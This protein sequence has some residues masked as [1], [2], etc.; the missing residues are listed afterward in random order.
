MLRGTFVPPLVEG[1]T[2]GFAAACVEAAAEAFPP[3]VEEFEGMLRGG[4][5]DRERLL[6]YYFARLESG[7]GGCTM[8][9]V[10]PAL[11]DEGAGP[12]VGRNYD[13]AVADL[14][15]CE[16]RRFE[17]T[18]GQRRIGYT[19]HWAGCADILS[20]AGLYVAIASLPPVDVR[21]PGVQWN[22]VVDMVSECCATVDEAARRC[23]GVRHLRSMSYLLADA[24]GGVGIVEATPETVRFRGPKRDAPDDDSPAGQ[25]GIVLAANVALGGC[26]MKDWTAT[27]PACV[28]PV[29]IRL[30]SPEYRRSP[31][32]RAVRRVERARELLE[33]AAP[34]ISLRDVERVLRDHRAPICTGDH[35][36]PDGGRAGTIWS[37]VS[38]PA[39][40]EFMIA[41]G[42]P[43]R[44][45]YQRFRLSREI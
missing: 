25:D 4:G 44:H 26:L 32:T 11:R 27:E 28:L 21:A 2:A 5:F 35:S 30:A 33:A 19:H 12:V 15:W 3:A 39:R 17:Q 40:G 43:C 22:I 6:P 10:P 31:P 42:L 14:R 9:A 8:F 23:A 36:Q 37:G 41:P 13:W 34:R 45:S 24:R 16:L 38:L 18:G 20:E 1:I 7:L 29:P